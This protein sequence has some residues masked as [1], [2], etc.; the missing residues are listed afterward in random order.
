MQCVLALLALA[1]VNEGS[2]DFTVV[3]GSWR[4]PDQKVHVTTS[5]FQQACLTIDRALNDQYLECSL[6]GPFLREYSY[7]DHCTYATCEAGVKCNK[8]R[9]CC[10]F[11]C[12]P[13]NHDEAKHYA[14]T[15]GWW[16][17]A[18]FIAGT[19]GVGQKRCMH[20][21]YYCENRV[22]NVC[23]AGKTYAVEK[24]RVVQYVYTHFLDLVPLL[25]RPGVVL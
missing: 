4:V 21:D 3:Q 14:A 9:A 6:T 19:P 17:G 20:Q 11:C 5:D 22:K 8:A 18:D 1:G 25:N 16:L 13:L 15:G 12:G 10:D 23:S 7:I 24:A 2:M